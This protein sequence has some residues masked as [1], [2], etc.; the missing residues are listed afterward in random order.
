MARI[1]TVASTSDFKALELDSLGRNR[2]PTK[3]LMDMLDPAGVHVVWQQMVHN[4]EEFRAYWLVKVLGSDTPVH[5]WM[6]NSFEAFNQ[7]TCKQNE[8]VKIKRYGTGRP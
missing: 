2:R 6:D 7:Y 3:E 1:V 8:D 4:D 5:V